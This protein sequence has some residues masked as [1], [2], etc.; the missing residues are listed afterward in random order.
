VGYTALLEAL[1][2]AGTA[3]KHYRYNPLLGHQKLN[4]E[5]FGASARGNIFGTRAPRAGNGSQTSVV[6]SQ[7][8]S[9]LLLEVAAPGLE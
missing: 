2:Q 3:V 4:S 7:K 5:G 6:N 8:G 9:N 1:E